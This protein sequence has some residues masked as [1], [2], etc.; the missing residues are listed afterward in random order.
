MA[1][2]HKGIE[3]A[4]SKLTPESTAVA[5]LLLGPL[6]TS[7]IATKRLSILR[8]RASQYGTIS[9]STITEKGIQWHPRE[10]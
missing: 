6:S 7:L 2:D 4:R 1:I 10:S 5:D 9:A 8:T 3:S